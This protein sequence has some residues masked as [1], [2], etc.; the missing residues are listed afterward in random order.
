M[1]NK[2]VI[3]GAG[4]AGCFTAYRLWEM[5]KGEDAY[6]ITILERNNRV[7]GNAYS[8]TVQYGG[9]DYNIDCGAQFFYRNPQVSYVELLNDLGLFNSDTITSAA[10][11]FNIYDRKTKTYRLRVPGFYGDL[12]TLSAGEWADLVLFGVF[13]IYAVVL[14]AGDDWEKSVD[15]WFA[16]EL[17]FMPDAFKNDIIKPFFYQFVTLPYDDI[18]TASAKYAVTYFVRNVFGEP[19]EDPPDPDTPS[20][21]SKWFPIIK[22]YQSRI[23]LDGV[24]K[25]AL[26]KA[27]VTPV[28][29]A[30]VDGVTFKDGGG[31]TVHSSKGDYD[32]DRLVLACHAPYAGQILDGSGAD[33]ALV[34]TLTN[35]PY[36]GI[37]LSIQKDGSCYMPEDE[38]KWQAV[39][40][41]VED[42][43][44]MFSAWFGPL[45]KKYDGNKSIPVFKSWGTPELSPKDCDYR[46][47]PHG[48][49]VVL[50]TVDFM[51]RRAKV[52]AA[53]GDKDVWFAGGW[54][55]WFDS[56]EA[57][58]DSAT[59]VAEAM[60]GAVQPNTGR[61]R[62]VS[63][64]HEKHAH[65]VRRWAERVAKAAPGD[66]GKPIEEALKKLDPSR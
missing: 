45:R 59:M 48:H 15:E 66:A 46:F 63:V 65:N 17:G 29:E 10:T 58:L 14:D 18:G 40:T 9:Q 1:S 28:L 7:G 47:V 23:G 60:P 42:K 64:A 21:D 36:A 11:G 24:M 12:L 6:D 62:M 51:K 44:I 19:G 2:V 52:K 5:Y 4:A 41:I 56:Q 53:Q 25:K 57:A 31:M 54:T 26:E 55:N 33:P 27:G 34:E 38:S 35:M 43:T 3:V 32:A 30:S 16:D 13:L 49:Y 50:P 37:G 39:N 8:T 22:T 61:S 20:T